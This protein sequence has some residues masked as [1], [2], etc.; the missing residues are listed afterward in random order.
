MGQPLST[1]YALYFQIRIINALLLGIIWFLYLKNKRLPFEKGNFFTAILIS[2]TANIICDFAITYSLYTAYTFSGFLRELFYR[3]FMITIC[4]SMYFV[5]MHILALCNIYDKTH[6]RNNIIISLPLLAAI[7]GGITAPIEIS[8]GGDG[9]Y[10]YGAVVNLE[11]VT[12][13]IYFFM[14]VIC[15]VLKHK[16]LKKR[17]ITN[18]AMGL[19]VW[20]CFGII[21]ML[22]P[23]L[24][25]S[26]TGIII[27]ELMNFLNFEDSKVYINYENG[28]FNSMA[29]RKMLK[30]YFNG[31]KKF[32]VAHGQ[33][34]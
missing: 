16:K 7:A 25:L 13:G 31:N 32:Y 5:H 14:S 15:L 29:Y 4:L 8:S 20:S 2:S 1:I 3:L 27:L 28:C 30:S 19:L 33:F 9:I 18:I 17:K 21:Q 22:N 11:Y 24:L 34:P 10:S 12:M 26:S 23:G 6:R